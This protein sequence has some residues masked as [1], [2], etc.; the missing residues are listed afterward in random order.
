MS[1]LDTKRLTHNLNKAVVSLDMT[2]LVLNDWFSAV[3]YSESFSQNYLV[4]SL[5][6][7]T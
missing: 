4:F 3:L 7:E 1:G 2:M 6:L 5:L